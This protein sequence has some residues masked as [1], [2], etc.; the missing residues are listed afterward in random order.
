M[1]RADEDDFTHERIGR[2]ICKIRGVEF[3]FVRVVAGEYLEVWGGPKQ[4]SLD[5]P[6]PIMWAYKLDYLPNI[7]T[8]SA[9]ALVKEKYP[10]MLDASIEIAQ[11]WKT[12]KFS[13]MENRGNKDGAFCWYGEGNTPALAILKAL[14]TAVTSDETE[15]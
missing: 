4:W 14:E 12:V 7:S 11:D 1:I 3:N 10:D 15:E 8:D 13:F 6:D 2:L 5:G 9:L